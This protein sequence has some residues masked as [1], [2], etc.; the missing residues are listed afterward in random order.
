[1]L[2]MCV[3]C[4]LVML[5]VNAA[6]EDP[7]LPIAPGW[8]SYQLDTLHSVSCMAERYANVVTCLFNGKPVIFY[9]RS[10]SRGEPGE[11]CVAVAKTDHPL[12]A[13][14]WKI[15]VISEGVDGWADLATLVTSDAISIA[16]VIK[17]AD[18]RSV[19]I[20]Y[21]WQTQLGLD[22]GKV[23]SVSCCAS[24][25]ASS[26]SNYDVDNL[27][28]ANVNGRPAI[29]A[30][31]IGWEWEGSQCPALLCN[32][33]TS[34][35][36]QDSN[37]QVSPLG[38]PGTTWNIAQLAEWQNTPV[39]AY[40]IRDN[41]SSNSS[42]EL[43][44]LTLTSP[45]LPGQPELILSRS[46]GSID[47]QLIATEEQLCVY[48]SRLARVKGD[49]GVSSELAVASTTSTDPY[50]SA[51]WKFQSID[52][53]FLFMLGPP[54]FHQLQP[55]LWYYRFDITPSLYI[56]DSMGQLMFASCNA[57]PEP[58]TWVLTQA[59][60]PTGYSPTHGIY[61]TTTR[62]SPVP[63]FAH[64]SSV[65]EVFTASQQSG[66]FGW[67]IKQQSLPVELYGDLLPLADG[68]GFVIGLSDVSWK[69]R[70]QLVI[71]LPD[72]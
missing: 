16:F 15:S 43:S 1:M 5:S 11:L 33:D 17:P 55:G 70:M 47:F 57:S 6:G 62:F 22:D 66:V 49:G 32:A 8:S 60:K 24:A 59:G 38:M 4:I 36:G 26:S 52:K 54:V 10:K 41:S 48:Y 28:V 39:V 61:H 21:A 58:H 72:N 37:W 46:L 64:R 65:T 35:P 7:S 30:S 20:A 13:A 44:L 45:L 51:A 40:S 67:R 12:Q 42:P 23:W 29:L 27:V 31:S 34:L 53:G 3:V 56:V 50:E 19:R 63:L 71:A 25:S 2:W 9:V 68:Y 18:T 69:N 14:D